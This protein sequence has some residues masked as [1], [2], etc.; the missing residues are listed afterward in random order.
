MGIFALPVDV[1]GYAASISDPIDLQTI[2]SRLSQQ[3]YATFDELLADVLRMYDNC[4]EFN[5]ADGLYAEEAQRQ[6]AVVLET[7]ETLQ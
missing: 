5:A 1:P 7:L 4:E 2:K 6:R 3:L